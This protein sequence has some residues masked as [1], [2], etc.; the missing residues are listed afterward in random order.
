L[1]I[2]SGSAADTQAM[3]DIVKIQLEWLEIQQGEASRVKTA[4][5]IFKNLGYEYRD[6]V[7]ICFNNNSFYK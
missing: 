7:F 5:H 1:N 6:Q 3:T 4:A 2:R